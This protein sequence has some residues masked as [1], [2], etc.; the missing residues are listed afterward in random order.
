[1]IWLKVPVLLLEFQVIV[2]VGSDPDTVAIHV[3][4]VQAGTDACS[5][6][7]LGENEIEVVVEV[8]ASTK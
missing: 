8:T 7:G 6:I 5:E 2:P 4:G 1:M 3:I